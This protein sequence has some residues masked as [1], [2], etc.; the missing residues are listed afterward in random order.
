MT[1]TDCAGARLKNALEEM[2]MGEIALSV[3]VDGLRS[4]SSEQSSD[5]V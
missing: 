3:A 2:R 5:T 4:W 1:V